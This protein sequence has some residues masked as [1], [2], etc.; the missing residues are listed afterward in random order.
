MKG[1]KYTLKVASSILAGCILALAPAHQTAQSCCA[2]WTTRQ[3]CASARVWC[4]VGMFTYRWL[5]MT[6]HRCLVSTCKQDPMLFFPAGG[7]VCVSLRRHVVRCLAK[8][9]L[10]HCYHSRGQKMMVPRGLEPRTLRLL[11][12]CSNQLSYE[13]SCDVFRL[14]TP[15]QSKSSSDDAATMFECVHVVSDWHVYKWL[16]MIGHSWDVNM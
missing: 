12:A 3:P 2:A 13:T 8:I 7:S 11:A 15:I 10:R 4:P 1:N 5:P 9:A 6:A 16:S 14:L